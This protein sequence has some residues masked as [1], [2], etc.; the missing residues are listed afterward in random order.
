MSSINPSFGSALIADLNVDGSFIMVKADCVFPLKMRINRKRNKKVS[1]LKGMTGKI[2]D[3]EVMITKLIINK[4]MHNR[5][6]KI[7]IFNK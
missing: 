5:L 4:G 7:I 1:F 2:V 3:L 6:F